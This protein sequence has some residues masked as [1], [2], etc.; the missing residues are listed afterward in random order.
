MRDMA[1]IGSEI[2]PG[3]ILVNPWRGCRR[4]NTVAPVP[5]TDLIEVFGIGGI[6]L[7]TVCTTRIVTVI[8]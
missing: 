6:L 4:V 2:R 3:D 5:G 7:E 1:I 8:R